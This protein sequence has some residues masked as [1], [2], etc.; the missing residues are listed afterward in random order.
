MPEAQA[1]PA[2]PQLL[3]QL[4]GRLRAYRAQQGLTLKELAA[5]AGVAPLTLQKAERG[6]NFTM[7]TLLRV[8]RALGRLDLVDGFLPPPL[9]SPLR[10]LDQKT[11]PLARRVRKKPNG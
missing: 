2:D 6:E 8:L 7:R 4:G 1:T 5:R 3:A 10:L 9:Q 11:G